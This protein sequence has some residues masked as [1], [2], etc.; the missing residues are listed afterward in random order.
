MK[1][2]RFLLL[3]I[4]ALCAPGYGVA[5]CDFEELQKVFDPNASQFDWFGHSV[6]FDGD[7]A[8]V[9]S[10]QDDDTGLNNGSVFIYRSNGSTWTEEQ[11]INGQA[12]SRG[13]GA[14]VTI[15]D[16]VAVVVAI[17]SGK[18]LV[19]RFNGTSWEEET[20]LPV[21]IPRSVSL[22]NGVLIVGSDDSV[23]GEASIF[24]YDED[25][26]ILEDTIT[27]SDASFDDQF[28]RAVSID[29]QHRVAII[30]APKNDDACP[31][32][33]N[34]DSGSSYIFRY[35]GSSWVQ[36][37]KITASDA[38]RVDEFGSTVSIVADQAVVGGSGPAI[39]GKKAYAFRFTSGNWI[40]EQRLT[41]PNAA[42][43]NSVVLG[44]RGLVAVGG[45]SGQSNL[46]EVYTFK[47]DGNT[48]NSDQVLTASDAKMFDDF[49]FA[50]DIS[51][52][53]LLV[54]ARLASEPT[55]SGAAYFLR[56][57]FDC[58]KGNVNTGVGP[59]TD[60]LFINGSPG[61]INATVNVSLGE[62]VT[63]AL[64]AAPEGPVSGN[65]LLYVWSGFPVKCGDLM[66]MGEMIGCMVNPT[67]FMRPQNPQPF[68]CLRSSGIPSVVCSGIVEKAGPATV[69]WDLTLNQGFQQSAV[70]T[71][72]AIIQDQGAGNATGYSVTNAATVVAE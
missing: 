57:N 32:S 40:E 10:F 29:G 21:Q 68:R 54:G 59:A 37:Q 2:S 64:D 11:K 39:P 63:F 67:P 42:L 66:A 61:N 7:V 4:F 43:G 44:E 14:S 33:L 53:E 71:L 60:V 51:G 41:A 52:S 48:W 25:Q 13:F 1:I 70:F 19:F 3:L 23:G 6:S 58:S 20:V 24:T 8:I 50:V 38:D 12:S 22:D 17:A 28:G 15:E 31:Q 49:G 45:V 34:C 26:W 55:H 30:G 9:G 56:Q 36:E 46:G 16:D 18:V 27:A 5:Q 72:Q 62:A 69:P 47:F 65:Y 35:D